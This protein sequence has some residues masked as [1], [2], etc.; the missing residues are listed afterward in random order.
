MNDA[1][2]RIQR[3]YLGLQL[4]NTLAASLIWGINTLFLLD[5]GLSVTE[6]FVANAFFTA[7]LVLFEIPTGVVADMRGRRLS[8][9]L[10]TATLAASTLLYLW[11]WHSEA[12]LWL[13][14]VASIVLGLGFTF[15][16]GAVQA[17][18]VDALRA[19]GYDGD[20]DSVFARGEIVQGIA[21]LAGSVAGGYIAQLSNLGAPYLIRTVILAITFVV[22][23]VWMHDRGF[24]PQRDGGM[25]TRMRAIVQQ[26]IEHGIR[27]PP[28]RWVIL[29]APFT[30]GV[31]I[32]AFYAMQPYLLELWGR[33]G[34]YGIAGLAAAIVAG[35][36]IIGGMTVRF[37]RRLFARRTT[38]M[39]TGTAISAAALLLIGFLP[40]F[41]AAVVLLAIWGLIFAAITPV[42]QAYLNGIIPS[43]QRATV[44][45]FDS[46]LGAAGGVASQPALGRIAQVYGY[47]ASYVVSA[48]LQAIAISLLVIARR[49][50]GLSDSFDDES[51]R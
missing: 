10:G 36:Q 8:Y 1:A 43:Q 23:Y 9:L 6:A 4:L 25:G 16:S 51:A 39:I 15:F 38:M 18:L 2:R 40:Y 20:L 41:W 11:M 12:S 33:P 22:A 37:V 45:S 34:A 14:A 17:W 28:A 24:E 42:R 27:N 26:S 3:I 47:P 19:S 49:K 5:G 44:L 13:W 35:A 46:M 48:A 7:G 29:A 31:M 50:R 30:T 21:M 32:Y